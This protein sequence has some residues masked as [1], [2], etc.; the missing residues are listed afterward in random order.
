M[1]KLN[2]ETETVLASL[3]VITSKISVFLELQVRFN[4][5]GRWEVEIKGIVVMGV[6][7]V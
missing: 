3:N 5:A 7:G 1:F 4:K 2:S 6:I